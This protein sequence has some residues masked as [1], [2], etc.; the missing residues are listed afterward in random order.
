MISGG[1]YLREGMRIGLEVYMQPGSASKPY[2]H[3]FQ[4]EPTTT[5]TGTDMP[6]AK[7][8]EEDRNLCVG[9]Q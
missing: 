8:K 4:E 1:T 3:G 6:Q 5:V 2:E 7:L 9:L